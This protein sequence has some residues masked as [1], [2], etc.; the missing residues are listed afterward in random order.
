MAEI[1]HCV[2]EFRETTKLD[3]VIETPKFIGNE[4]LGF[5]EIQHAK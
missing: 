1:N 2:L 3:S 4:H 5:T